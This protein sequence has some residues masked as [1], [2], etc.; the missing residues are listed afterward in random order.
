M[1]EGNLD[2]EYNGKEWYRPSFCNGTYTITIGSDGLF[3]VKLQ[4]FKGN[5]CELEL[6]KTE[7]GIATFAEAE[8]F[9]R[10]QDNIERIC[11]LSDR[12]NPADKASV[13]IS[14]CCHFDDETLKKH[15][16]A[17]DLAQ[18]KVE[19]TIDW[20]PEEYAP[21]HEQLQV[22]LDITREE[23]AKARDELNKFLEAELAKV[24]EELKVMREKLATARSEL[25]QA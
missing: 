21:L 5:S 3:T 14:G 2:W 4:K 8:S 23:L 22:E 24:Q 11:K 6:L 15:T 7:T 13:K 1:S 18:K 16:E 19:N 17:C 10:I 12:A 9:C 25:N 20:P